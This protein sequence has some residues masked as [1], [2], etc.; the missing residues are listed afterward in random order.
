MTGCGGDRGPPPRK[1]LWGQGTT[2]AQ[3]PSRWQGTTSTQ[4]PSIMKSSI[5]K[6]VVFLHQNKKT[7]AIDIIV[8]SSNK[9]KMITDNTY[10]I[11]VKTVTVCEYANLV[12][13][14][15]PRVS[16]SLLLQ[17]FK[18][19]TEVTLWLPRLLA[20]FQIWGTSSLWRDTGNSATTCFYEIMSCWKIRITLNFWKKQQ[21]ATTKRFCTS[22]VERLNIQRNVSAVFFV[23]VKSSTNRSSGKSIWT[24]SDLS[25]TH[26][27]VHAWSVGSS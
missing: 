14:T 25:C 24:T 4:T 26:G 12:L 20:G 15:K 23:D 1:S 5:S 17:K 2:S 13:L 6:C 27:C 16:Q 11:S 21:G 18:K 7:P 22:L 10:F 19:I 3:T 9:E 8:A